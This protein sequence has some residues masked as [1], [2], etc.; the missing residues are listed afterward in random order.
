MLI[1]PLDVKNVES[2]ESYLALIQGIYYLITGVWSLV[3]IAT[4]IRVTGPKTDIWLVKTVGVLVAVIGAVL[5]LAGARESVTAE[6]V[7]LALGCA[8]GLLAIDVYYA[9]KQ[10]ISRIYLLDAAAEA[11]LVAAWLVVTGG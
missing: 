9:S 6:I 7:V 8:A 10:I 11:I 4:F 3:S 1:M 2:M 5:M